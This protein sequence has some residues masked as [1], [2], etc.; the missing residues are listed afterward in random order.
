ME[1]PGA[2]EIARNVVSLARRAG[3]EQCDAIVSMYTESNVTVRLGELEKLI[4]AGSMALGLRVINQGRTAVC[5]TSDLS[6][7]SLEQF[8]RD[9]VDLASISEPDEFAGLPSPAELSNVT[10]ADGL[11]LY[12]EQIESLSTERK[13]AM[14]RACEGAAFAFD[15]RINNSDGA[16]LS[17][18]VG[19]FALANSLG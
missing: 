13:V 17:T 8:V 3:A 1:G 12:D 16:S 11:G 6:P 10:N 9:A 18:R 14:A 19:Q 4:E 15:K 7:A 2:L 5:S